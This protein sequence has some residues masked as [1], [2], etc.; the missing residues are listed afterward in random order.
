MFRS[1]FNEVIDYKSFWQSQKNKEKKKKSRK[2]NL[3]S[4]DNDNLK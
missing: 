3:K 2:V 1:F 4:C